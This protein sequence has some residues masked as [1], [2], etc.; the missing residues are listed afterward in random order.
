[1]CDFVDGGIY[2]PTMMDQMD[3]MCTSGAECP[4]KLRGA[5]IGDGC[6]GG[7]VGMCAFNTGKSKQISFEFFRGHAMVSQTLAMQI[8]EACGNFTDEQAASKDCNALLDQMNNE[9]GSFD[10]YNIYDTSV[11]FPL[12]VSIA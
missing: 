8:D 1:M 9:V 11:L 3:K 12:Q 7:Q 5:A 4:F 6:W 10:I 2:I